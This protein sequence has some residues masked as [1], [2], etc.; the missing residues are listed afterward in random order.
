MFTHEYTYI[1]CIWLQSLLLLLLISKVLKANKVAA[2]VLV[3]V[4]LVW[5]YGNTWRRYGFTRSRC[6][7]QVCSRRYKNRARKT[8]KITPNINMQIEHYNKANNLDWKEKNRQDLLAENMYEPTA[9]AQAVKLAYIHTYIHTKLTLNLSR[10]KNS[11]WRMQVLKHFASPFSLKYYL[12]YFRLAA[13]NYEPV[14][15]CK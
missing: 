7:M 8:I 12:C 14:F 6:Y 4:I 11:T 2:K 5:I 15:R 9:S 1:S 10:C 13:S 3:N